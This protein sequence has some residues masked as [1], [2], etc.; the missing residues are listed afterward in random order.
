MT[1]VIRVLLCVDCSSG[2]TS[3]LPFVPKPSPSQLFTKT[4]SFSF[5]TDE[6][7]QPVKRILHRRGRTYLGVL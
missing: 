7:F 4:S 3:P 1:D 2:T 5:V 6:S